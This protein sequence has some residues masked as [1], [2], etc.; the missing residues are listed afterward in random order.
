MRQISLAAYQAWIEQRSFWRNPEYAFFTFALPIA[1]LIA[2]GA[3]KSW[4]PIPGTTISSVALFVPG[5]LA[6]GV[7]V[8]AYGN[9][10][11]RIAILRGDGVLK[12]I[13][14]TPLR[15]GVYLAGEL[16][17]TL[18]TT[19]LVAL[20]TIILG[21]VAFGA[22]PISGRTPLLCLGLCVGI[23]CFS[24]LGLAVST[25]IR[26]PDTAGPITN[27]T[28]L[29]IAIISGLF[30]P[31]LSLPAWLST[32]V[33]WFPLRPLAVVLDSAYDPVMRQFP[34]TDL[35]IMA[36]WTAASVI[37]ALRFFRWQ[38]T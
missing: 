10:A 2:I 9:L 11:Q 15:P 35:L 38:V 13:R 12:R 34:A 32:I 30:D 21:D 23:V 24:A 22:A 37:I 29:P 4:S 3:T 26:S 18:V 1:I 17:S 25:G 27:A 31:Q 14:T 8:A 36:A 20:A 33:G 5:I 7:V 19:L 16:G 28:Y 6:F